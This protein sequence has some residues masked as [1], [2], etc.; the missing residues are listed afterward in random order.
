[1]AAG[2]P[3]LRDNDIDTD[4]DRAP[5]V[6]GVSH[7][8]YDHGAAGFRTLHQ[9][10]GVA[11]E[12]RYDRH[13]LLEAGLEPLLLAKLHVQIDRERLRSERACLLHLAAKGFDIGAPK[14]ECSQRA[15]IAHGRRKKRS[16]RATH[17]RKYDGDVD[18]EHLAQLVSHWLPPATGID[19]CFSVNNLND[20][21]FNA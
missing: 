4:I 10:A 16:Y 14:R 19:K 1:M 2:F 20:A 17:G 11:P 6:V 8:V 3:P 9:I 5:G 21:D 15:C 7:G 18:S 12:E 13:A